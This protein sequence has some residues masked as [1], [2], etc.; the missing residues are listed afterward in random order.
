M[1]PTRRASR[2]TSSAGSPSPTVAG[3]K[4]EP[5]DTLGGINGWLVTK[6][7]PKEAA[8]F[9]KLLLAKS[10]NQR[11]AAEHGF[12]IP[13]VKGTQDAIKNPILR[14]LAAE[15]REL[16]VPPESSTTRCSARRSA[17]S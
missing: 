14:Q 10:Q 8:D 16:E 9:L 4:G 11:V 7:S 15:C 6:G 17:A 2:T 5:T 3:G 12:Y 1:P 13:V